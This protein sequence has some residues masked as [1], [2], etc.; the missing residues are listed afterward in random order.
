MGYV[1][2]RNAII[3]GGRA[4]AAYRTGMEMELDRKDMLGEMLDSI[5]A[6]FSEMRQWGI[7]EFKLK[8]MVK[9]IRTFDAVYKSLSADNLTDLNEVLR[10]MQAFCLA[11]KVHN[12]KSLAELNELTRNIISEVST[13]TLPGP[14][15]LPPGTVFDVEGS[16]E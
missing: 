10:M 2:K 15:L 11:H 7:T 8:N 4:S 12:V 13:S 1:E 5:F 3:S 14:A 16:P 6:M 9:L